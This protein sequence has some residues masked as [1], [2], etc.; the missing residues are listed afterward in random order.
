MI[1]KY[2]DQNGV[3]LFEV[4]VN[5][6]SQTTTLRVQKKTRGIKTESLAKKEEVKLT[7]ECERELLQ[8]ESRGISWDELLEKFELYLRNDTS[9]TIGRLAREDY[10]SSIRRHTKVWLARDASG[11]NSMDVRQMFMET[12]SSISVAHKIKIKSILAKIFQYGIDCNLIR[13]MTTLPTASVKFQKEEDKI[14]EILTISEIRKLLFAAKEMEHQWYPIWAVALLTGMRNGELFAL[15]WDDIDFENKIIILSKSYNKR[16][17]ETKCTKSGYWRHIPISSEL[18][19]LLKELKL[20]SNGNQNV[21]P[22]IRN[23]AN[24]YQAEDL[25]AFCKSV[26]LPSIRFHAL[27]ACFATQ[28]IRDGI[29]PIQIQKICGWK[30]LKTMQRYIRLAGIEV[31]GATENLKILPDRAVMGEVVNLFTN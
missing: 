20:Q 23:W 30:D 25:R 4:Y 17:R 14:P 18:E 5:F 13:G 7:R 16:T 8:K 26:G 10:I 1:K 22:R 28:L 3:E 24:G 12:A 9:V 19:V 11:I 6:R 2:T 21:L 15:S 31:S 29:P 27:R